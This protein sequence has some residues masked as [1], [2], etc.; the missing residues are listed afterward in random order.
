MKLNNKILFLLLIVFQT[1]YSQNNFRGQIKGIILDAET[2]QHVSYAVIELMN[3]QKYRAAK[4]DGT[5][6]MENISPGN[7]KI[8]VTH[9]NYEDNIQEISIEAGKTTECNI[10]LYPVVHEIP[11]VVVK[12]QH[13]SSKL[14]DLY[15]YSHTL[16]GKKLQ[17]E[18]GSTL[19]TTLKN[20]PGI[21]IRSMGPAPARPV[22]RGLSGDRIIISEDG[23]KSSD[24]S[25]TSPDHAVSLEPF[26]VEKVEVFRGPKV[27]TKSPAAIGGVINIVKNEIPGKYEE[28][29]IGS[30]GLAGE[31]VNRSYTGSVDMQIPYKSFS[32]K[33]ELSRRISENINTPIGE[34][35]NS[36]MNNLNYSIGGSYFWGNSFIGASFRNFDLEYGIPGG[37]VGAHPNGV[38]IEMNKKQYNVRGKYY[39][40]DAG[41]NHFNVNFSR[42]YYRHV[43]YESAGLIGAEFRI[44]DYLANADFHHRKLGIFENGILGIA[45][46]Y[47]DFNVGGFVFTPKSEAYNTSFYVFESMYW[48]N[49][50]FEIGAR[51]N[52]D[53]I[54]PEK[55][56]LLSGIGHIRER[57]FLTY[58]LSFSLLYEINR[59][60]NA[61]ININKSSR[62]PTIEELYSEGPH[63]A[64]YSFETGNPELNS[65]SG[66]GIELFGY[67][68]S[69][70]AYFMVNSFYNRM[71]SFIVPRNTGRINYTQ[72]L[73]VYASEGIDAVLYGF[74][75]ELNL[76]PSENIELLFTTDFTGGEFYNTPKP[77]PQI[78]PL[79]GNAEIKYFAENYSLGINAEWAATQRRV[80]LFE[81]QT[82]GYFILG[83]SGQYNFHSNSLIH[84]FSLVLEN[85]FNKEYRNHLSRVKSIMPEAGFNMK[86]IYKMFFH[87]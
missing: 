80:D 11:K 7:H 86:L 3:G 56:D 58:S 57:N 78:P 24:L 30:I 64:A 52:Y 32:A 1:V 49:F 77:L 69:E 34:L 70:N 46:S 37:F 27:L 54:T 51:I 87:F 53:K 5:F 44:I 19:A 62:V 4:E 68:K 41:K 12:S 61:G 47:R 45:F 16:Q 63:L 26:T 74:E 55:E 38:D 71:N 83:L 66:A 29:L 23:V 6:L 42:V 72:L 33:I 15:E 22:M 82:A 36:D 10:F 18:L 40:D 14:N 28:H 67:Y 2:N 85:I 81:E 84:N 75:T 20:Q 25:A 50:N 43:E 76:K 35:K 17:K 59:E 60:L 31:T 65:E 8:K 48:Q 21:S 73:P 79:K 39:T 13:L 9:I